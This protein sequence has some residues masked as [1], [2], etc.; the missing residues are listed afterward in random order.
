MYHNAA[1]T[2]LD[3]P[4]SAADP[5][6]EVE[7]YHQYAEM[8][9]DTSGILITHRLGSVQFCDR[10]LLLKDGEVAEEGT[11]DSLIARDGIYAQM[12]QMQKEWY[13]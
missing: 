3:E 9:K 13:L 4:S 12:Y 2:V 6:A 10:I 11:H 7:I 1:F 5:L 8:T